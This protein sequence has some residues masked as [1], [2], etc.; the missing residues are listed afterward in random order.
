MKG[1]DDPV[2]MYRA[3]AVIDSKYYE[4]S[5]TVGLAG[6]KP[7]PSWRPWHTSS[8]RMVGRASLTHQVNDQLSS[9]AT[10]SPE[11]LSACLSECLSG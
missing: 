6:P 4:P 2:P 8:I 10:R 7:A 9:Y 1:M 11:W 5:D 3:I